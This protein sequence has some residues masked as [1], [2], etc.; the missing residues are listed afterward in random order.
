MIFGV[1]SIRAL[2]GERDC[3]LARNP[4]SDQVS[5]RALRGERDLVKHIEELVKNQF[6]SARSVGSAT[7]QIL[8]QKSK[9]VVSIRALRGERD[10]SPGSIENEFRTVSIRALRGERDEVVDGFH[11]HLVG[12]SIRAL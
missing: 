7:S 11:R 5:I 2:R 9:T 1:V 10:G 3:L 8:P 12:V 4:A 6:Q